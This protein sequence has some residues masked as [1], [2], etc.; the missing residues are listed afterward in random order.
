MWPVWAGAGKGRALMAGLL[1]LAGCSAEPPPAIDAVQLMEDV[2][3][4]SDDAMAGRAAGTPGSAQAR[5]Y[6]TARLEA[7]GVQPVAQT[8][9]QSFQTNRRGAALDTPTF[10]GVNL[11]G[12]IPSRAM[13]TGRD[14]GPVLVLTAHYDHIGVVDGVI[15]NGADDNASGVA[16]VLAIAAA[17]RRA[18]PTHRV[19]LALLDNEEAGLLGARAFLASDIAP[20]AQIALNINLDMVARGDA[21]TLYV[22]GVHHTPML[23]RIM[24]AVAA[25]API[26]LIQGY[27]QPSAGR[28]DWTL[29][30]DHA[31]FH[32]A[33]IP[34][35]YFGV[36]DHP[37]YHQ[38][39]DDWDKIPVPFFTGAVE[40]ILA[41]VQGADAALPA[42]AAAR[43]ARLT[44]ETA[45]AAQP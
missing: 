9:A 10:T 24:D 41:A 45:K 7:L 23:G 38:P 32:L 12:E 30:S 34:F 6:L 28:D 8:Y 17:L 42:I 40:T 13:A 19:I 35:L 20:R 3:T 36:E 31:V 14:D 44:P 39:S 21:G 1:G 4:L 22:A 25:D 2:R 18:P 16:A 29:L 43:Q 5:A 33:G 26:T 15:F 11:I 37:D 27:D